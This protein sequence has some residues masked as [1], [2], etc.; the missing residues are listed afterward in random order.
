MQLLDSSIVDLFSRR[1]VDRAAVVDSLGH[2]LLAE[3]SEVVHV[4]GWRIEGSLLSTEVVVGL[5]EGDWE[6]RK[7]NPRQSIGRSHDATLVEGYDTGDSQ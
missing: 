7:H 6:E 1:V 4:V 5:E 2:R 3:A